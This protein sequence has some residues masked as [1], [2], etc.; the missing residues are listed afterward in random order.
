[1]EALVEHMTP[2]D[3]LGLTVEPGSGST[4]PTGELVLRVAM[5]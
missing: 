4:E 2:T 1:M 3:S 5:A